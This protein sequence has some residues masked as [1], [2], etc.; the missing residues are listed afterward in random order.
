MYMSE[1]FSGRGFE[2]QTNFV[3]VPSELLVLISNKR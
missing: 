3:H 1:K 2:R